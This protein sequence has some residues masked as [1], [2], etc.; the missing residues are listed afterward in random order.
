MTIVRT[1]IR[2]TITHLPGM[3]IG[4]TVLRYI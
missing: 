1:K 4:Q 3:T 2:N